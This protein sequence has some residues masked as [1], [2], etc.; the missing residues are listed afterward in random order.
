MSF[1][2]CVGRTSTLYPLNKWKF[3]VMQTICDSCPVSTFLTGDMVL[4]KPRI[5]PSRR[6]HKE[7]AL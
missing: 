5:E 7:S 3:E 6:A 1:R 2:S 4:V